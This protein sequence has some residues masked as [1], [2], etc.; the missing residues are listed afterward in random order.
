MKLKNY[1]EEVLRDVKSYLKA[2]QTTDNMREAFRQHWL[3][4]ASI[5]PN[6]TN[7]ILHQYDNSSTPGI[8]NVTL[9]VPTAGGKTFIAANALSIIFDYLPQEQ[10]RVVAWFVPSDSIKEQTLK[11]LSTPGHPYNEA[12]HDTGLMV[13]VEGKE[14]ALMGKGLTPM[15]VE[16]QLTVL[17]LSAQ[18]FASRDRD[19]LLSWRQNSFFSQWEGRYHYSTEQHIEGA[20]ELSL[21]QWLAWQR[22]VCVVD[23]SHNFGTDMRTEMLR[24]L[25]PSFILNLTATPRQ[26]SNIISFVDA[27]KLR[28]E[29]MVK[30]PVVLYNMETVDDVI[31]NAIRWRD[32][33]ERHAIQSERQNNGHYIR[34]IVL[35][36]VEPRNGQENANCEQ[37]RQILI[38]SGIPEEQIKRK[39]AEPLN[40]LKGI[41]LMKHD[42]PVRYII[43][44]N[45][46]KEGWDCPFAYVLAAL[47]NRSAPIDVEQV[48]GRIL[49][50]PYARQS[51]D[52]L[53]NESYVL[54]SKQNFYEAAEAVI[55]SLQN[56][57]FSRMDYRMFNDEKAAQGE[58]AEKPHHTDTQLTFWEGAGE[59]LSVTSQGV[60]QRLANTAGGDS[61]MEQFAYKSSEDYE[62]TS[63]QPN[64]DSDLRSLK[65]DSNPMRQEVSE[66]AQQIRLPLFSVENKNVGV[67]DENPH[68]LLTAERLNRGFK[69]LNENSNINLTDSQTG[70]TSIDVL[71]SGDGQYTPKRTSVNH[72]V[73]NS[74]RQTFA[75]FSPEMKR[76]E[77]SKAI[78]EKLH[79]NGIPLKDLYE[80][81]H[82]ALGAYNGEQLADFFIETR[83][84]AN[85]FKAKIDD[86]L[87]VYRKKQLENLLAARVVGMNCYWY[88]P[89][90]Q[91]VSSPWNSVD[92]SLYV[93]EEHASPFEENIMMKIA[94]EDN[95]LFWHR[96]AQNRKDTFT[97][98]GF[99]NHQPDFIVVLDSDD[100]L[101]IETKGKPFL[102]EESRRKIAVGKLWSEYANR[103]S[104]RFHYH[105]YMIF[106]QENNAE[107]AV[108]EA[109]L[110][111][112]IRLFKNNSSL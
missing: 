63:S 73:L 48:M 65:L 58:A 91:N 70:V 75:S 99:I 56:S 111:E 23:E 82:R 4:K 60:A 106:T 68:I 13:M 35:F 38:D 25:N 14:D 33:L 45:A 112:Q 67:F 5:D 53:L 18:S 19:D 8:P 81:V 101:L 21:I 80:Y 77:L 27:G 36:Q 107:G 90:T 62:Q 110:I 69:I 49:R 47:S 30:L 29:S 17:V 22:P 46:L 40:E 92:R 85:T 42:C 10:P 43:T 16:E 24:M 79:Y 96:N 50:Q 64:A 88:F 100:V 26:E 109:G 78:V 105:Y 72:T 1:Q 51:S 61:N 3:A 95:V 74:L 71:D 102:N 20:D 9:K 86:L 103:N 98:N 39:L 11:N 55:R 52:P 97:I 93:S 94:Q 37:V 87:V 41:D 2:L 32:N 59:E 6:L 44:V 12:L 31:A 15:E 54:T 83:N 89:L 84:T 28:K 108:S 104:D 7:G 34:P 66:I 76:S 57:G